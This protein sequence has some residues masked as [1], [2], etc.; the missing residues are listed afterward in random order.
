MKANELR[1]GNYIALI[2]SGDL[3]EQIEAINNTDWFGQGKQYWLE[4]NNCEGEL[5]KIFKPI[6]LTEEWLL[7]FGFQKESNN[8][9]E[10]NIC[11]DWVYLYWER[12]AGLE[13]SVNKHSLMQPHI[14]YV[15]ELQ[16]LYF[17]LT[18]QELELKENA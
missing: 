13:I 9:M 3:I 18:G 16:N 8:W 1:I 10:L 2:Q 14:L 15:H 17:A 11:H 7:K 12:L 4:T 5:L 6:P